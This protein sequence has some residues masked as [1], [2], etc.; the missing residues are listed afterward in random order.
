MKGYKANQHR[1]NVRGVQ[2]RGDRHSVQESSLSGA[3]QN[4]LI[5]H[6]SERD[7]TCELSTRAAHLS[8]GIQGISWE[9]VV[10]SVFAWHTPKLCTPR[11]EHAFSNSLGTVGYYQ[12][13][14]K[15]LLKSAFPGTSQGSV[16]IIS[17]PF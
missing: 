4:G 15:T 12:G 14:V 10:Q 5:S 13:L 9:A 7:D 2:F 16:I 11:G 6:G 3:A 17:R 1:E 8:P